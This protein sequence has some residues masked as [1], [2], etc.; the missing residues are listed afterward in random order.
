MKRLFR[1]PVMLA[2]AIALWSCSGD[3]TGSFRGSVAT[4]D[5]Q[6]TSLFITNGESK[7]ILVTALDDQGN[8][9]NDAITVTPGAGLQ[10]TLDTNFLRT[11]R[12]G[13]S[14]LSFQHRYILTPTQLVSTTVTVSAGGKSRD[15]PVKVVPG[16]AD[17]PLATVAATG[18]TTSDTTTLT[19][20][21]P[22]QFANGSDVKFLVGADSLF[23]I[24]VDRS[25]DGRTLKIFA[26]PGAAGTG[27]VTLAVDFLP[28]A[29]SAS[30]T[31]VAIT[32]SATVPAMAGTNSPATAPV[33]TIPAA[34]VRNGFFDAGGFGA[35]TCG[36][37]SGAPCQLYKFTLAAD[38]T[39]NVT[40]RWS[41]TTDIGI[42]FTSADGATDTGQKC[43]AKGNGATAQPEAC[44][45]TLVAGTY[46]L[47]VVSFGPFYTP[48]DPNP[49]W[50]S[51]QLDTPAP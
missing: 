29:S 13:D 37:N 47:A 48:P 21:A 11:A 1:G 40:A 45:I 6:P 28:A 42:Y 14:A 49:T 24:V 34:G 46:L 23:A 12:V 50:V 35:A 38:A 33:I 10:A 25:T 8:P 43:D 30:T 44:P 4:V 31:D 32:T 3:P 26:P 51:V 27:A 36:G 17:I 18:P 19:V 16:T 5:V 20:P 22:F 41:N 2:A 15:V 9:T 7:T 39:F